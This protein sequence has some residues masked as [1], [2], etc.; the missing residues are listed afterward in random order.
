MQLAWYFDFIAP[1]AYLQFEANPALF[2]EPEIRRIAA[3]PVGAARK[4]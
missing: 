4:A 3:L 2:D 1:Y